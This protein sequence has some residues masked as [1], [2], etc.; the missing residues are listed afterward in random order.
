MRIPAERMRSC[1]KLTSFRSLD[2]PVDILLALHQLLE[3]Q[4]MVPFPAIGG[5]GGPAER[6]HAQ[7]RSPPSDLAIQARKLPLPPKMGFRSDE[8]QHYAGNEAGSSIHPFNRGATCN[9][10]NDAERTPL[11]AAYNRRA[12]IG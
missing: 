5:G 6:K 10:H 4:V 1:G 2:R 11:V 12:T 8:G 9:G 3:R 7:R